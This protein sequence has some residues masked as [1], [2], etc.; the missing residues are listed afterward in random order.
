MA[1]PTPAFSRGREDMTDSV[2]GG[3]TLAIPTPW[4][5]VNA[6]R[7]Q[8]GVLDPTKAKP[9]RPKVTRPNPT[10]QTI[11]GPYRRTMLALSGAKISC[12]AANGVISRPDCSGE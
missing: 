9:P 1:E 10:A 3:I 11:F 7:S 2:A 8:I 4:M 6:H 12:A 5:K